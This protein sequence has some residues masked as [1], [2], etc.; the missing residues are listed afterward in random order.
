MCNATQEMLAKLDEVFKAPTPVA[1]Q[2]ERRKVVLPVDNIEMAAQLEKERLMALM[3]SREQERQPAVP[4]TVETIPEEPAAE[5]KTPAPDE[6][7]ALEGSQSVQLS[8][9]ENDGVK[10][11]ISDAAAAEQEGEAAGVE[12]ATKSTEPPSTADAAPT[13]AVTGPAAQ[14]GEAVEAEGKQSPAED[15]AASM[16][17]AVSLSQVSMFKGS[18]SLE[19]AKG[20]WLMTATLWHFLLSVHSVPQLASRRATTI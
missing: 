1:P 6:P 4:H 7:F 18:M 2:P 8:V 17:E 5:R 15:A 19:A 10:L 12:G 11:A 14:A 20:A 13:G 16:Q 9:D 3:A